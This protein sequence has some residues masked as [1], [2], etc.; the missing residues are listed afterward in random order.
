[1]NGHP[2]AQKQTKGLRAR[3]ARGKK[4]SFLQSAN[5]MNIL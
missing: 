3:L 1:M 5:G 2:K 4:R